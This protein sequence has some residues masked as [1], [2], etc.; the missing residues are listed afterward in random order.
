MARILIG[1]F[2]EMAISGGLRLIFVYPQTQRATAVHLSH[3]SHKSAHTHHQRGGW[4]D[5]LLTLSLIPSLS[6]HVSSSCPVPVSDAL[7]A[8]TV[9]TSSLFFGDWT[10]T[11]IGTDRIEDDEGM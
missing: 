11:T 8:G 2:L 10:N 9:L 6:R 4:Y 3:G 1:I 5:P 7:I